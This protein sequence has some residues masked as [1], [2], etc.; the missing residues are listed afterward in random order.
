MSNNFR[1]IFSC[2]QGDHASPAQILQKTANKRLSKT[3]LASLRKSSGFSR[4]V[5]SPPISK[6]NHFT[7]CKKSPNLSTA[8]P[9]PA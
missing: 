2:P 3:S 1:E 5:L 7:R 6:I 4:E 9:N 8:D